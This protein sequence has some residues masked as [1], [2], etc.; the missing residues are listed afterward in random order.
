MD[1]ESAARAGAECDQHV[2]A[3]AS[4]GANEPEPRRWA[5]AAARML[6]LCQRRVLS[7]QQRVARDLDALDQSELRA[8]RYTGAS[9]PVRRSA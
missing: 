1:L 6:S 7:E 4:S 3:L 8:A 5:R 9:R 2:R